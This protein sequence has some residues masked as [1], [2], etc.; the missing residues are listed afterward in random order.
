M[1]AQCPQAVVHARLVRRL[2]LDGELVPDWE[3]VLEAAYRRFLKPGDTVVDVGAHVGRHLL[4]M[5]EAVGP[6][7]RALAF[8]PLP[9]AYERLRA[10]SLGPRAEL[11]NVA[12]SDHTGVTDFIHA[13]GTPEESGIRERR[14]NHPD[15]AR[16][17]RIQVQVRRL[18]EFTAALDRVDFVKIDAEGGEVGILRGAPETMRRF[19]PVFSVE[20]GGAAYGAYGHTP[21]TMYELAREFG[22][23]P[24]DLFGAPIASVET[25]LR[26]C[27]FVMWDWFLVPDERLDSW[28]AL[29]AEDAP[30]LP[31]RLPVPDPATPPAARQLVRAD[32]GGRAGPAG[33]AAGAGSSDAAARSA[34]P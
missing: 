5:V 23:T 1:S 15:L 22:Y 30:A 33:A 34:E 4:R 21:E 2:Q 7:G 18:D 32:G 28:C 25:W 24:C 19:R 16:P 6:A 3:H 27:D 12:L 29:M 13:E 11:H 20:Y 17:K 8:E 9:F 31:V 14:Y 10:L 26:V